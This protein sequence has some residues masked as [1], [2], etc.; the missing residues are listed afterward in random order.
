MVSTLSQT[1]VICPG[2]CGRVILV[3]LLITC[4]HSL[5]GQ[6]DVGSVGDTNHLLWSTDSTGPRR[7]I[8][9]HGRRAAIFGNPQGYSDDL[10]GGG[11]EVW[12]YPVQILR[13]YNVAFREQ[14]TTTVIDGRTV[15]RRIEYSPEA[16]T[17]I[18]AGPDF[19][20][21]EK[22]F[23]PLDESGVIV[24]Y[25]VDSTRPLDIEVRFAPV[26][27][28]MWP[29]SIGGQET[30]WTSTA[31]GYLLSE[32]T[33]RFAAII[34]SPDIVEHDDTPNIGQP[35]GRAPGLAF[36]IRAG[37]DRDSARVV[38]AGSVTG[39]KAIE[40]AAK[41]LQDEDSLEKASLSHYS[42]LLS[43]AL[44]I[45]TPDADV[46]RALNWGEVAVDQAWVCNPDLGCGLVA[47]YG[48]SR[49]A[50]RPQYD[51]FFA[52]DG[53]VAVRALLASGQY[54]RARDELEFILKYQ[55]QKNGMIW[56]EL[57]QSAGLLDWDKYPYKF[58]HID[59]TFDFLNTV[60][61][62]YAVTGDRDFVKSQ[63]PSIR[64]AFEYCRTL[65]DPKD[66]LPRIPPD[67]EGGHEQDALSDELSLS[68]GWASAAR[69]FAD[70]ATA[71]GH[72][73][74]VQSAVAA[75]ELARVGIPQRYW[76]EQHHSW[77]SGYTRSNTPLV[78]KGLGPARINGQP[79]LPEAQLD[80]LL[81]RLAS[82]DFQ[83]DWGARGNASSA[84]TYDPD[85][86]SRGSVWATHTAGTASQFWAEHRSATA[87]PIWNA[88][89]P[90]SSL[91]SLGHMH[92]VLAGNYY[93]E[94]V[95]SVPEQTWSS[96]SFFTAAVHGLLGIEVDGV[97]NRATIAPHLPP[98][99]DF[100]TLRNLRV[101][102][103]IIGLKINQSADEIRFELQ[104][105]G[106]PV[107]IVF[108]P[109]IPIGAELQDARFGNQPISAILEKH[110]QDAHVKVEFTLPHGSDALV[111]R[112]AGGV[113]I[114]PD[115]PQLLVGDASHAIKI[116]GVHLQGNLYM[117]DFDYLPS[118]N[119]GF[120]LRTPW[121]IKNLKGGSIAALSP[122]LYRVTIQN[123]TPANKA[124]IYQHGTV[125][126]MLARDKGN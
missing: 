2:W 67:K 81:D 106:S 115:Q 30:L 63:W 89:V 79:L 86:Y 71:A 77:I 112:F 70:L 24:G 88:L 43:W 5:N 13:S 74:M 20:V 62:Y 87:W 104:N 48:P 56:H 38:I 1:H 126:V 108:D 61:D 14:G 96:A 23:V 15:L 32:L 29:A 84:K 28:L 36:T 103:S 99:W 95:E 85:S 42:K 25:E 54:Q 92:E 121:A 41:L 119:S 78:D 102:S 116:T 18:Y 72:S 90:W 35:V 45:E 60:G 118:A 120:N 68:V 94:E 91:D 9:V 40:L 31:S 16:V 17:R 33:H 105:S 98:N 21:R 39:E 110:S 122:D 114:I 76:D 65:I 50:R 27:D 75:G 55:N 4:S 73:E 101:G 37:G 8:S 117:V 47:G 44:R 58:V 80:L 83:T 46:N 22:L 7:F 64:A 69:S 34:K 97:A 26:L 59:L 100:V 49:N 11:L 10:S 111:I 124:P 53:I 57:S 3:F 51:W 6:N 19:I 125:T 123:S 82:S 12:A 93:H 66:G 109:E 52:G 113:S 107:E